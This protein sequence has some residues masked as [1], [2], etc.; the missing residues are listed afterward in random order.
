M[1]WDARSHLAS[2]L[3]AFEGILTD[4]RQMGGLCCTVVGEA[5]QWVLDGHCKHPTGHQP[6]HLVG[7]KDSYKRAPY[8]RKKNLP[9]DTKF[10]VRQVRLKS[11]VSWHATVL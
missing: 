10:V 5:P 4:L 7:A 1:K 3:R 2:A 8:R 6:G 9:I 11:N